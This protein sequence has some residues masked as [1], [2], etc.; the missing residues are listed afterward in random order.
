MYNDSIVIRIIISMNIIIVSISGFFIIV[1]IIIINVIIIS[2]S[3]SNSSSSSSSSSSSINEGAVRPPLPGSA[4]DEDLEE[5]LASH[6][7]E[8][9]EGSSA[10]A[11]PAEDL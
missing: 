4:Q 10:P 3:S 7:R 9:S 8:G 5:I 1:I 6:L 2:S 11:P